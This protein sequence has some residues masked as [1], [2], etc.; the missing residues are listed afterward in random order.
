M[1]QFVYEQAFLQPIFFQQ[2]VVLKDK[3]NYINRNFI[4]PYE[5]L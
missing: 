5:A 3:R 4:M 1:H 2:K